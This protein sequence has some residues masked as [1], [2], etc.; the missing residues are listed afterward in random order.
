VKFPRDF[1]LRLYVDM[2]E[3]VAD[4]VLEPAFA[5]N[6]SHGILVSGGRRSSASNECL[7]V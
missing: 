3:A 5:L 2:W 7:T 4:P 1:P 6:R